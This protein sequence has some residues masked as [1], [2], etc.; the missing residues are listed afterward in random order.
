[1]QV[2][3]EPERF[4]VPKTSSQRNVLVNYAVPA[5]TKYKNKW[6]VRIFAEWQRLREVRVPV[7]AMIMV[8]ASRTTIY[9]RLQL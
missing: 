1:M 7:L 5:S 9:T 3:S 4:R 6:A 8:V 2:D